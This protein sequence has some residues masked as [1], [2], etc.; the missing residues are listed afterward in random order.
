MSKGKGKNTTNKVDDK[1][2][3]LEE[4]I[5]SQETENQDEETELTPMEQLE[6]DIV[7][8]AIRITKNETSSC[9]D[10]VVKTKELLSMQ[11]AI[12]SM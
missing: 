4:Q 12:A 6:K 3:P 1:T 8:E 7:K 2:T 11:D 9:Y 10:L 5:N